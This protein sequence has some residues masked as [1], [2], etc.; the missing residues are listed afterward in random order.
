MSALEQF[1]HRIR[2][3][4]AEPEGVLV[5]LHGRGTNELDL[6]PLLDAIDPG[7]RLVG[8]TPRAPIRLAPGGYHWYIVRQVGYPDPETFFPAFEALSQWVDALPAEL[9]VPDGHL[10]LGGF[11]MGAVMSYSLSLAK[12]RPS[13]A[14]L[15]ALSGFI[16]KVDEFELDLDSRA[17][18]PVAIG[19]GTKDPII[20]V[21]F[22]RQARD[23]LERADA[24]VIYRESSMT[25]AVDP[26]FLDQITPW[27][28]A[29]LARA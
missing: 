13:P 16:P 5:L 28:Q 12:G 25:H 1:P 3:A 26:A 8:I 15:I 22:G 6:F 27:L 17:G 19:H 29:H 21:E 10:V 18:L 4:R 14:A 7:R 9:G 24:E 20:P 11:S 2:P 23:V